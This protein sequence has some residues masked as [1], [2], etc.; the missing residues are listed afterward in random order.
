MEKKG[1]NKLPRKCSI[2]EHPKREE[3]EQAILR[4]D[5]FSAIARNYNVSRDP[6]RRHKENGHVG[7]KIAITEYETKI[8]YG[9][10]IFEQLEKINKNANTLLDKAMSEASDNPNMAIQSMKEIRSQLALLVDIRTSMYDMKNIKEFQEEI[11]S[12][13]GEIS[14]KSKDIFIDRLKAR[15]GIQ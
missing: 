11:I 5:S 13:L 8:E 15:K 9:S 10:S 4:G 2:C 12:L 6:V 3:I 14:P 1:A 7:R